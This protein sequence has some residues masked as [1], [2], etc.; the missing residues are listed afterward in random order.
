MRSEALKQTN[1]D[2]RLD[3]VIGDALTTLKTRQQK[4]GHLVFDLEADATIP[5]EYIF[6]NH[7]LDEREPELEQKL[8][9]YIRSIQQDGGGWPLYHGGAPDI[10]AS[11]KAYFALKLTGDD[12]DAPHMKKARALIKNLGGAEKT[13]V[14][15]RYA[16]A[17]FGEVPWRAVPV[18]P[19]EL[20]LMPRW[21]P[22]NMWRFSYWSRTVIAPLLILAALKPRAINPTDTH[23]R[24]LFITPPELIRDWQQNPTGRWTGK[25]FLQLDKILQKLEPHFP[26]KTRRKAIERALAFFT[27]R[28]NGED[29]L[30]A[31]FPAM[32]NSVMAMEALGYP[33]DHEALVTAKESIRL[34]V[35]DGEGES[36]VQPCLSPIWDT[37]L[38]LHALLE[39]GEAPAGE[40]VKAAGDWL[41]SKQ[42]LD[43][44]GDWALK[45]PDLRPGGWAFQYNND[46][47]PDVD[48][49]AVVAMALHRTQDPGYKQAIDRAEEWII[50]MQSSNGG[51]GAFDIDNHDDYLNHI[52]FADHG[53]LLD[54]PTE[55]VSARCLSFLGQLGHDQSHEAVA[56]GV[57]YLKK[58]QEDDGCWYG[59]WGTN[60]IY[61]TWS[62]LAALNA[63]GEDMTA[64]YVRKAVEWLKV[65]QNPD[66]GW[67]ESGDSYYDDKKRDPAPST[68]SQTSWALLG[69]MAAGE[70]EDEC[71]ARGIGWLLDHPR[72]KDGRWEEPWYNAVGFPR[73][74]YLRYHG[75]SHYFPIWALS[76]YRVLSRSNDKSVQWGM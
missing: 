36:F 13:N 2:D 15:T 43:V 66:G 65:R 64:P 30:G 20:M 53:A 55:D 10:S 21:F 17:L 70:T 16:L 23:I 25:A 27:E 44:K 54:P 5:A 33:K 67:G 60:Y 46:H 74:F 61:G 49:T 22:A 29:G 34:L 28:L 51:W 32:A 76:R 59:R 58:L 48:D 38:S 52:P 47:Y 42:I 57:A 31:I 35:T 72:T 45:A 9:R 62:V 69:L 18:M 14:F 1:V 6:L 71:V 68:P 41:A 40:T 50:G 11:V 12:P 7:F 3:Q 4:D 8:A 24:E 19:V 56:R 39:S 26:A 63:V 37:S 73:V 75:Y